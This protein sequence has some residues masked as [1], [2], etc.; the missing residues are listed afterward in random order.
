MIPARDERLVIFGCGYVGSA[1]ARQ[2]IARG[3][4]VTALTR[5]PATAESLQAG[6]VE[7]VVADLAGSAWHPQIAGG[8]RYVLNAVS[9]GG[10]GI[11]GYRHSYVDGMR[12]ILAWARARG[13]IGT[14]VYTSSTSVYPQGDGVVVD[15]SASSEGVG[16]R[17]ELLLESERLL[18]PDTGGTPTPPGP[19]V[20]P[21]EYMR[22][23]VLRLAGIYGPGRHQLL[24]QVRTGIVAGRG[25][26]RLNLIHLE[27]ICAA[28]WSAFDAPPEIGS[29][30]F[31]VADDRPA[32][33]SDVA[34][35]LAQRLG[36][37][38]P[39]FTGLPAGTRRSVT[40]DR[41]ISNAKIKRVLGWQPRFP[42]YRAGY[43]N[44]LSQRRE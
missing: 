23:F 25:G 20:P 34:G 12:S 26:H 31:N 2:A 6:G 41:V 42:D 9:A 24:D 14:L 22:C 27:D 10:G 8:A 43:E 16:E 5:N 28:I 30:V 36:V 3:L 39:T 29:D 32:T 7:P 37:G 44:I 13:G 35:W 11:D 21:R 19:V 40:P 15:E 1:I 33:K 18:S 17:G 38:A 4:R